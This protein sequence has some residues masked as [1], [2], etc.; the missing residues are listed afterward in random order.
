MGF[1]CFYP[2]HP[3]SGIQVSFYIFIA[4]GEMIQLM[5]TCPMIHGSAWI[6]GFRV[7]AQTKFRNLTESIQWL[8]CLNTM[9]EE[10][11]Q[12]VIPYAVCML[13]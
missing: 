11:L 4:D 5:A 6:H 12:H 10:V 2:L 1:Q 8:I 9:K 3:V 7:Y 13:S